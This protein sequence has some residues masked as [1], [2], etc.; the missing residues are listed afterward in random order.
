MRVFNDAIAAENE[1]LVMRCVVAIVNI[2]SSADKEI[3]KRL[4]VDAERFALEMRE[5]LLQSNAEHYKNSLDYLESNI[6]W[7]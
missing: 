6:S 1:R 4:N 7:S 5:A 3:L 2:G